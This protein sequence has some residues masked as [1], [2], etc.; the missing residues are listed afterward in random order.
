[1][2][3]LAHVMNFTVQ[4]MF[5]KGRLKGEAPCDAQA[6][7]VENDDETEGFVRI[8]IM[9]EDEDD[10]N[11]SVDDNTS[12]KRALRKLRRGVVEIRYSSLHANDR[13]PID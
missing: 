3:C 2:P 10:T 6:M 1:M 9:E 13:V 4:A 11:E 5:G 12:A 8:G 7:A